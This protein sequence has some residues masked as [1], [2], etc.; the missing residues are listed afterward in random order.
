MN[1]LLPLLTAFASLSAGAPQE[2]KKAV[3]EVTVQDVPASGK[4]PAS[5]LLTGKTDLPDRYR[6]DLY[7]YFG[8][9]DP[10]FEVA[11]EATLVKDGKFSI[12]ISLFKAANV[13]GEYSFRLLGNP[14]LQDQR[15]SQLPFLRHDVSVKLGTP[16]DAAKARAEVYGR[17]FDD[18]KAL[19][20][21]ADESAALRKSEKESGKT[22]AAAWERLEK[23]YY[24]RLADGAARAQKVVEY[25][26]F[27]LS[28]FV[29]A[30]MEQITG[31]SM[32]I[33]R[34]AARG[35]DKDLREGRERLD[36]IMSKFEA[37]LT[38]RPL[39]PKI[40]R[41]ELARTARRL[42]AAGAQPREEAAPAGRNAFLQVMLNLSP[43]VS[44]DDRAALIDLTMGARELFDAVDEKKDVKELHL[45][46]DARLEAFI[47]S[48]QNEK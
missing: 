37:D 45:K 33:A 32:D 38:G 15:Y 41:L 3:L 4:E 24:K 30:G 39:D 9:P 10:G 44:P 46:L 36:V 28:W 18:M 27:G 19:V 12:T 35:L 34:C 48:L 16:A 21:V 29:T 11:R 43:L 6:L 17:L 42:L 25:R 14:D 7:A 20:A 1:L 26:V 5:F 40:T 23:E 47:K 2:A 8:V 22:D 31:I 13:A